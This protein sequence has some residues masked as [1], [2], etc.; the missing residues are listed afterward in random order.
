M[1]MKDEPE[2]ENVTT[3]L[4]KWLCDLCKLKLFL[5]ISSLNY[6]SL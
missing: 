5:T 4:L 6:N 3:S 2:K 1:K